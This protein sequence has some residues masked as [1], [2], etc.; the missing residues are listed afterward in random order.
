[1]SESQQDIYDKLSTHRES[2]CPTDRSHGNHKQEALDLSI[3]NGV[4]H[5]AGAGYHP[6]NRQPV[7]EGNKE[8]GSLTDRAGSMHILAE[9]P[10]Q[11]GKVG[12][13]PD[14]SR[15]VVCRREAWCEFLLFAKLQGQEE[16]S[17]R[18][19]SAHF[20]LTCWRPCFRKELIQVLRMSLNVRRESLCSQIETLL[21]PLEP[22][23]SR[24]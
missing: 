22:P 1:M 15:D 18:V 21:D 16:P 14:V 11:G 3:L 10:R 24:L 12:H 6:G 20:Q 4:H 9:R 7:P 2:R 13:L 8:Q 5:A 17:H 19:P 23:R